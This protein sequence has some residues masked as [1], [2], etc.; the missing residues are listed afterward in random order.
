MSGRKIEVEESGPS[1]S[2]GDDLES[3]RGDAVEQAGRRA[4]IRG[5]SAAEER[6]AAAEDSE[7][8]TSR[9]LRA[10][11]RATGGGEDGADG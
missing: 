2:V 4:S 11:R 5:R 6:Q 1:F 9:L 10:K 8:M 3:G 7:D